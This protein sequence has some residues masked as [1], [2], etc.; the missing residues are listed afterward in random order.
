LPNRHCRFSGAAISDS[1][2][3]STLG[4]SRGCAGRQGWAAT[5]GDPSARETASSPRLNK[6]GRDKALI[7]ESMARAKIR[8]WTLLAWLP[9][10]FTPVCGR[11]QVANDRCRGVGRLHRHARAVGP[12]AKVGSVVPTGSPQRE[13]QADRGDVGAP[14]ARDQTAA[15]KRGPGGGRGG[16]AQ[17]LAAA[18]SGPSRR[19]VAGRRSRMIVAVVSADFIGTHGRSDR[20]RR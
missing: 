18:F 6:V 19:S 9:R 16:P 15:P 10:S 14:S 7:K 8:L 2:A 17:R 5:G 11:P 1:R 20:G 13:A 4:A 12:R 3:G